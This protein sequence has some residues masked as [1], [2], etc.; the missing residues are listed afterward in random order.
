MVGI[1][2]ISHGALSQVLIETANLIVCDQ[3]NLL[4]IH[5]DPSQ[6]LEDIK[7]AIEA[8]YKKIN[9]SDEGVLVLAD[10]QGGTPCNG[11]FMML[12]KLKLSIVSG[13]NLPML[14]E[15]LISR[16]GRTL[17]E[18]T[19]IAIQSGKEGIRNISN[20]YKTERNKLCSG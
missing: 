17:E 12:E 1:L 9:I 18:L 3:Q 6:G 14:L 19:D 2:V 20:Y 11:A 5:L 13:V 4:P 16:N 8:A 7:H 15:V 10:L